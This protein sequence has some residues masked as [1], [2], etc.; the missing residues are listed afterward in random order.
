[1]SIREV[2]QELGIDDTAAAEVA[3]NM[4]MGYETW[5]Q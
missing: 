4:E 2:C 3:D 1:M 5:E